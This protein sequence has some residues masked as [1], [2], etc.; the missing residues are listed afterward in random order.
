MVVVVVV[1]GGGDSEGL[2]NFAPSPGPVALSH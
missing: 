1:V 2:G